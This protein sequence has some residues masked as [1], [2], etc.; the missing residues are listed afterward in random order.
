MPKH[1]HLRHGS[2]QF[3]PRKRARRVLPSVNWKDIDKEGVG[4]LGFIGYKVGMASCYVK[5]N[6][7]SSLTKG[8]R[9]ILPATI[10]EF[11]GMKIF[12]VRF[13]KNKRVVGEI[14]NDKLDKELAKKIRIPKD[15]KKK[16]EDFKEEY[17]DIKVIVYSTVKKTGIKKKPD[18]V[19]IGLVGSL[20]EKKNF[21]VENMDKEL[22]VK[23]FLDSVKEGLVDVRGVT[24]GKGTQGPTKRFGLKLKFHKS[25]KGRR[26]PGSGGPWHPARVEYT[27]PMAG[28]MGYF[29]RVVY[30]NK[31]LLVGSISEKDINPKEGFKKYGKVKSD[32]AIVC[33]SIQGPSKRQLLI[34]SAL[35]PSKTQ[36]K[37]NYE[38]V[39][40]R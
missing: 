5:D 13:Y 25:E 28:Q 3:Y 18:V 10:I 31:I 14:L 35:R 39:E 30:N 38:F 9:V 1:G 16:V 37:K 29:T 7:N 33:G 19:E 24:K 34:T 4:L 12:S 26:G 32:Y 8:Q 6:S 21:V 36:I 22:G 17:D 40:L 11:P 27:Q 2:L 20:D 23:E 15:Y